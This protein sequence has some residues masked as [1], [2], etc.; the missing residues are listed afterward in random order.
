MR[1]F[2]DGANSNHVR[3]VEGLAE[4]AGMEQLP[5]HRWQ[6]VHSDR[7]VM[8]RLLEDRAPLVLCQCPPRRQFLR[9]GIIAAQR[10]S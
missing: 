8:R 2:S 4:I 7:R 10:A 6:V 5:G 3:K 1:C 9:I